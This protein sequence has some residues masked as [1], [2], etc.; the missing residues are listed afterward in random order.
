MLNSGFGAQVPR[1]EMWTWPEAVPEGC[2]SLAMEE[3]VPLELYHGAKVCLGC[4]AHLEFIRA[5]LC[6]SLLGKVPWRKP[7]SE[8]M[9]T[10][11]R[12]YSPAF[13]SLI[14]AVLN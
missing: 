14:S 8:I 13:S 4:P 3:Q 7:H 1:G 9:K 11:G 5:V 2:S 10:Q 12:G 6:I